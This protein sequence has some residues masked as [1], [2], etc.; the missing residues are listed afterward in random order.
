M[1]ELVVAHASFGFAGN[2]ELA[3]EE[4]SNL[5][6]RREEYF[7]TRQKIGALIYCTHYIVFETAVG[8]EARCS[9][10]LFKVAG[11]Q[12]GPKAGRPR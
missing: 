3:Q 7:T 5:C 10:C 8:T 4:R 2:N 12:Q 1:R 6:N 11:L 9:F